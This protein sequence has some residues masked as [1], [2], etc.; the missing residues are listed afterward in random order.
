MN[1]GRNNLHLD[2]LQEKMVEE[3]VMVM[4]VVMEM[5]MMMMRMRM[6][7]I[8]KQSLGVKMVKTQIHLVEE[9]HQENQEEVVMEV[10]DHHLIR[11]IKMWDLEVEWDLEVR[12]W[13]GPQGVPGVQGP[14]GPQ[15]PQGSIG[16]QGPGGPQGPQG[17][18]GIEGPSASSTV[19][20]G[21]A[22]ISRIAPPNVVTLETSFINLSHNMQEMIKTQQEL[23]RDIRDIQI[24][25]TSAMRDLFES[26]RQRNYDYLFVS[27]P[28]Y[29]GAN[30]DELETW[31]DQ[32]E[33]ACQIA[34][35]GPDIKKVALGK[36]KGVALD[37]LRSL[38]N[39]AVWGIVK[40]KLQRCFS[41]DK[42]RKKTGDRREY[43]SLYP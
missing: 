38:D 39:A 40:D 34:G 13:T 30:K 11:G 7:K 28:V 6:R 23:N 9:V 19:A 43:L 18:P 22:G 25:Q 41:E 32:I 3:E 16:P 2:P 33:V 29:N 12:G 42:T 1:R 24:E 27:I 4:V 26:T 5:T 14:Q 20:G 37:A 35:R 36:L 15:G 10:M 21:A 8:Q 31:L 17:L